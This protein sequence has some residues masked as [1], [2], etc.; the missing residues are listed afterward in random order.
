[1]RR[2]RKARPGG[3]R[4]ITGVM[5]N[6]VP[7]TKS[8]NRPSTSTW[9]DRAR[10]PP[11]PRAARRRR[12]RRR[13]GRSGR[14]GS[15]PVRRACSGAR[16]AWSAARRAIGP[17]TKGTSTAAGAGGVSS[18]S[19]HI[20][21]VARHRRRAVRRAIAVSRARSSAAVIAASSASLGH[22]SSPGG[23]SPSG[24]K[25]PQL[26][27]PSMRRQPTQSGTPSATSS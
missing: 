6:P 25:R 13:S 24:K 27:T 19:Q 9:R 16:C 2:G 23:S 5:R 14:R 21:A 4:P 20:V 15:S 12:R 1:M 17:S 18:S 10:S 22:H 7:V 26:Q 3:S 11:A 8:P